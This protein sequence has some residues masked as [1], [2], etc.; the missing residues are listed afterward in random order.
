MSATEPNCSL[1]YFFIKDLKALRS[2]FWTKVKRSLDRELMS[3][4]R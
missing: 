4:S 3:D 1:W 2:I